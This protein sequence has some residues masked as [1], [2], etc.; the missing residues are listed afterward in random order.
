MWQQHGSFFHQP[1]GRLDVWI[2]IEEAH[3]PTPSCSPA[4][5]V[6]DVMKLQFS[7]FCVDRQTERQTDRF[8]CYGLENGEPFNIFY[9]AKA[10][11]PAERLK[12]VLLCLFTFSTLVNV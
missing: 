11:Q 1:H 9:T 2:F 8:G 4:T 10:A 6:L 3:L 7:L 12:G 5:D